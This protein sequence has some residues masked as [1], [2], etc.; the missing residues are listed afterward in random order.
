MKEML[1]LLMLLIGTSCFPAFLYADDYELF[2]YDCREADQDTY[3]GSW[4]SSNCYLFINGAHDNYWA[5]YESVEGTFGNPGP[6]IQ[7]QSILEAFA[8]A[9]SDYCTYNTSLEA[10][11]YWL[12]EDELGYNAVVAHSSVWIN[13]SHIFDR[14]PLIALTAPATTIMIWIHRFPAD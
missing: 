5:I 14:K 4:V 8:G 6:P 2:E 3:P 9:V 12:P 10:V 11:G 13:P 1:F 7:V